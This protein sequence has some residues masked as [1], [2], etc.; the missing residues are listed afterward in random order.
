MESITSLFDLFNKAK[1]DEQYR[2]LVVMAYEH[3]YGG[4]GSLDLAKRWFDGWSERNVGSARFHTCRRMVDYI[5][6][7]KHRIER[8]EL[9]IGDRPLGE[10]ND[11]EY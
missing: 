1:T 3:R 11:Y 5:N 2:R 10:T 8:G 9:P 7:F 6:G 4:R